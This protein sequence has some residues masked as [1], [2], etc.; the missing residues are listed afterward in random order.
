MSP[1]TRS[2]SSSGSATRP[3]T[4]CWPD[5]SS[6]PAPASTRTRSRRRG[7]A[8]STS[9]T[10][11]SRLLRPA[12]LG[13]VLRRH[14][15]RRRHGRGQVRRHRDRRQEAVR[16]PRRAR[17]VDL[18]LLRRACT[19]GRHLRRHMRPRGAAEDHDQQRRLHLH[20]WAFARTVGDAHRRVHRQAGRS[21][22]AQFA[23][24]DAT[25]NKQR[26]YGVAHYDTPDGQYHAQFN[27]LKDGL[28][29]Y[30]ITPK[31]DQSFFLDPRRARRTPARSSRR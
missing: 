3:R 27:T 9:T 18:G 19:P 16:S 6:P 10:R 29:K 2:R 26:V 21:G 15:Q 4:R 22:K 20:G 7:R 1:A 8:T 24:D 25:K 14:G 17:P 13:R 28:K 11:C 30:K 12:H 23:G 5:R 31:A